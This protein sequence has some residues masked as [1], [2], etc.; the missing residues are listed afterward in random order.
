MLSTEI[1]QGMIVPR[2]LQDPYDIQSLQGFLSRP[3]PI[4]E[5]T[6]NSTDAVG[7]IISSATFPNALIQIPAFLAKLRNFSLLRAGVR[8]GVRINGTKFHYGKL[9]VAW[10]PAP[11]AT[12]DL[13]PATRNIYSAS[14][15]PHVIISPTENEV[16]EILLPYVLPLQYISLFDLSSNV[17]DIGGVFIYVLNALQLAANT[18]SVGV[19]IFASFEDISVAGMTSVVFNPPVA[20]ALT[21]QCEKS[22]LGV[23][24][25]VAEATRAIT[26]A[27]T[28]VPLVGGI[29]GTV[30]KV[31]GGVG[32]IASAL[33][34]CKPNSVNALEPRVL[35]QFVNS[36]SH[37]L[38]PAPILGI[39]PDNAVAAAYDLIG[40]FPGEM[41]FDH[42]LS[43]P[44]LIQIVPWTVS[45]TTGTNLLTGFVGPNFVHTQT[46][47]TTLTMFP[48]M[49]AWATNACMFW[50]GSMRYCVQITCSAF[51]SGRIRIAW[52]PNVGTALSVSERPNCVNHIL[53][54]QNETEFFFSVPYLQ[55]SPWKPIHADGQSFAQAFQEFIAGNGANNSANGRITI[56]VINQL[57]HTQS[58]VP[59]ININV[60]VSCGDDFQLAFPTTDYLFAVVPAQGLT[61]EFMRNHE[62]PPI[63]HAVGFHDKNLLMGEEIKSVKDIILRPCYTGTSS[64]TDSIDIIT[65]NFMDLNDQDTRAANSKTFMQWYSFIYRF[66]RGSVTH[67][68]AFG[69]CPSGI[70]AYYA[71]KIESNYDNVA[72]LPPDAKHT[73]NRGSAAFDPKTNAAIEA[74]VPFYSRFYSSI[75]HFG[76]TANNL[77]YPAATLHIDCA[78]STTAWKVDRFISAGDD[79]VYGFLV[80]PPTCTY[81]LPA[82]QALTSMSYSGVSD[83]W[84]YTPTNFIIAGSLDYLR[85]PLSQYATLR[86]RMLY[87]GTICVA[88]PTGANPTSIVVRSNVSRNPIITTGFN[89]GTGQSGWNT[90]SMQ[91]AVVQVQF[92]TLA[93]TGSVTDPQLEILFV[94][95]G[96][97][98]YIPSIAMLSIDSSEFADATVATSTLALLDDLIKDSDALRTALINTPEVANTLL[99]RY[100]LHRTAKS[101]E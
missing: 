54:V 84:T 15:F 94:A 13:Y 66:A 68:A 34:F 37:G 60:W 83:C 32:Q 73:L 77:R 100:R 74:T 29:A 17:Y 78:E 91:C 4:A 18:N 40:S 1:S 50:R 92:D 96:G 75:A 19:T 24:S 51:H 80:G 79:F 46:S 98:S 76:G 70:Q 49:T 47:G 16:N 35:R 3:F 10:E 62:Y 71:N 14:S 72:P 30:S 59:P 58:P 28:S 33:G 6:W 5:V 95:D 52:D 87:N 85:L 11:L 31:A 56:D 36:W 43:T 41:N 12:G 55:S 67:K 8:I 88:V 27:L 25:G 82:A 26:G 101:N 64:G 53:D 63:V 89:R 57:T 2:A 81:T 20:Q 97:S 44:S 69:T 65:P 48:T 90:V 45:D 99:S 38:E 22:R 7:S 86:P 9:L 21:E 61:R 93:W 39:K 23:V 42:V